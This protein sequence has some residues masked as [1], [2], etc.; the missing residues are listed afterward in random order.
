MCNQMDDVLC[1][2]LHIVCSCLHTCL[3]NKEG[4]EESVQKKKRKSGLS[5][6][7][8]IFGAFLNMEEVLN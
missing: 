7:S 6:N 8:D 1:F 4:R 3:G 5:K 2:C